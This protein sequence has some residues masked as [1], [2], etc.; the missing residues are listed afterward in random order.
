[1]KKSLL[2]A[3]LLAVAAAATSMGASAAPK[4]KN[5]DTIVAVYPADTIV[6]DHGRLVRVE[7]IGSRKSKNGTK[8]YV[9]ESELPDRLPD[10]PAPAA[11][12]R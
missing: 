9:P 7:T 12:P 10:T 6:W 3:S 5:D 8:V 4:D 1:M 11:A 2:I